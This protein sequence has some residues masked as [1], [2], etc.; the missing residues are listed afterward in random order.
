[1][2]RYQA[3]EYVAIDH[4]NDAYTACKINPDLT[5]VI[6]SASLVLAASSTGDS[7]IVGHR[8]F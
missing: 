8:W 1:M 6:A 2:R 3:A 4:E 5:R 7:C